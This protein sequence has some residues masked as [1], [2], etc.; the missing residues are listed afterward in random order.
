MSNEA[1]GQFES[2][3]GDERSSFVK[4]HLGQRFHHLYFWHLADLMG[5]LKN[6]LNVLSAEVSADTDNI[7][8]NTASTQRAKRRS[9]SDD[10]KEECAKKKFRDG[11][12]SSLKTI[13]EGLRDANINSAIVSTRVAIRAEEDQVNSFMVRC[14]L[15]SPEEKEMFEKVMSH[16]SARVVTY[17]EELKALVAKRNA[18]K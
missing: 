8:D 3:N 17:E 1:F 14:L 13:G 4:L 9:A 5:V 15:C 11:V 10:E 16:H 6:V 12:Q 2:E 7:P 18:F